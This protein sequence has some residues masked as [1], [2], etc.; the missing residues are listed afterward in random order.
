MLSESKKMKF[1]KIE[2]YAEVFIDLL[3]FCFHSF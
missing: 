2:N 1:Y 3:V